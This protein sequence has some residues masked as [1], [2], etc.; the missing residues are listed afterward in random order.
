M[1]IC[2]DCVCVFFLFSQ[3]NVLRLFAFILSFFFFCYLKSDFVL[4][5]VFDRTYSRALRNQNIVYRMILSENSKYNG[6]TK[7]QAAQCN[8]AGC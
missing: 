6:T 2:S 3:W 4:N 5:Q 1:R 7:K 8:H